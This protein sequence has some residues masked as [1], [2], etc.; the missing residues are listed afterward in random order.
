MLL[1][2]GEI[3][4]TAS[5]MSESGP[6]ARCAA[7]TPSAAS[8]NVVKAAK[9]ITTTRIMFS[10]IIETDAPALC[11][12][13]RDAGTLLNLASVELPIVYRQRVKFTYANGCGAL[14]IGTAF[15]HR[16]SLRL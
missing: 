9:T 11:R 6:A 3:T 2:P 15:H 16:G 14:R 13:I 7:T 1:C 4:W 12:R 5:A 10:D 8:P